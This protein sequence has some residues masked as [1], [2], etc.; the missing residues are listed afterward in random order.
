MPVW[1]WWLYFAQAWAQG[2]VE[3]GELELGSAP[4]EAVQEAQQA[5]VRRDFERAA[6]LWGALADAGGGEPAR[7]AQAVAWYEA[8]EL[9]RA[10]AAAEQV[11]V[12][13]P[14]HLM[15]GNVLGLALVDGGRV[16]EGLQRLDATRDRAEKAGA[17]GLV[18]MLQVNRGLA[19]LDQGDAPAARASFQDGLAR[20]EA[21]A[22][23]VT[24]AA[25]RQGLTA[26]AGLSGA[27][28]G[29][30]TLLG[31]GSVS[32]A[33]AE[34]ERRAGVAVTRRDR[35]AAGLDLAA[36]L[37]AEG[38]L[39]TAAGK[40]EEVL[41]ESRGSGMRRE[42]AIALGQLGLV[43][44]LAGR[45]PL[46]A[47]A[48]R[49][50]AE[51]ARG[52]GYRVVE[53][54]VRCELG[55]VLVHL[56]RLEEADQEQ[57]AA[58]LLL[59]GMSYPQGVARQAELGG[60]VAAARGDLK[61]A[62]AALSQAVAFHEKLGRNLDAARVATQLAAAW[63]PAD[64]ATSQRW[65][66]RA[67]RLFAAAGDPL[68]PAHVALACALS[69]ARA[70]RLP[71]ALR[72]FADAAEL[73]EKVGSNRGK[74]LAAISRENAAQTLVM[75]GAGEEVARIASEQGIEALV[76]RQAQLKAAFD[77][78]DR[79]L[80]AYSE[81]RYADARQAFVEARNGFEGLGETAYSAR[82]RRAAAWSQ[83]NAAVAM[84]TAQALPVWS[85]LV[86]ETT[87]IDDPELY[88]R[89]YG[90]AALAAHTLGQGDPLA[91]LQECAR[92]A[93]RQGLRDVAARCHGAVAERP[94]D[95]PAR[96]RAARTSHA[97][98]PGDAASVYALYVV[99]VDAFNEG[100]LPL[101][102]E[103]AT[104]ARPAAGPLAPELDSIL[105]ATR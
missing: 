31:K 62:D 39:D 42:T 28:Q 99:A 74:T 57:R 18:A 15:A 17:A 64:A 94:G 36:V 100:E 2:L 48:L 47:D 98:A 5:L 25:A 87:Q 37:R 12:K 23:P 65:V 60:A 71:E 73:A 63:R 40:L 43:H 70:K 45:F 41:R 49:Q 50:G 14:E 66:D 13:D 53:V 91:R 85:Q 55:M 46:A 75:L 90:A 38:R 105:A 104:L 78:Y 68:G 26:V 93:E 101:A 21:T 27:D 79:G 29:V 20:A 59:A 19:L 83:Y 34:A 6:A 11:L 32:Q 69:D 10:R 82:S 76:Q 80:A 1:L 24:A 92:M 8:G 103:L 72:G 7:A 102:R 52:G 89:V 77:Q 22:D 16:A 86:E 54:D 81:R 56:G 61:T 88:V 95:L 96:A 4:A 30:G 35:I 58:G 97:F 84:P 33:R 67:S 44:S 9:G 51:E 3:V